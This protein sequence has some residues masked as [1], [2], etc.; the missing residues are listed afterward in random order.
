M[1]LLLTCV[2]FSS[3]AELQHHSET[4]PNRELVS[5][6][7]L[8]RSGCLFLSS[9]YVYLDDVSGQEEA[10]VQFQTRVTFLWIFSATEYLLLILKWSK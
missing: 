5:S 9:N 7:L 4:L 3:C 6:F 10:S 1:I 2:S 8:N